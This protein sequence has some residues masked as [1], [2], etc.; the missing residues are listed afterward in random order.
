[1]HAGKFF[2][3]H[4]AD[5]MRYLIRAEAAVIETNATAAIEAV[6]ALA[7]LVFQI[8][9]FRPPLALVE[10]WEEAISAWLSGQR[11]SEVVT[12]VDDDG[13]DLLQDAFTYRLP[14]AMEAI[15]VYATAVGHENAD[16]LNGYAAMAV[17]AGH[18]NIS[19]ILL[20]RA[21]LNS[22]E[23]AI[24][25]ISATNAS[26]DSR[27]GLLTWLRSPEITEMSKRSDWPTPQTHH[28]W[29]QFLEKERLDSQY[30]WTRAIQSLEV[31]WDTTAPTAGSPVVV[32]PNLTGVGG[33]ILT[34]DLQKKGT[35]SQA[36]ELARR[37][38]T[39][40]QVGS[41]QAGVNI[42]FFGPAN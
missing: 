18:V 38:I 6:I 16:M 1:M 42:D 36:L 9:P 2:D 14:W 13:V 32:E 29:I 37:Y 17:E 22:R 33:S 20:I 5:L 11:A 26:F 8:A 39:N 30:K 35:Y 23:A 31:T 12:M 15:R 3:T 4:L 19:V 21:G 34:P 40:A 7:R 41:S 28:T 25:A 10:R 27:S 24:E